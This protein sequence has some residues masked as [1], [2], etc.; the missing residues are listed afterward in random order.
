MQVGEPQGEPMR[1]G[2]I[3][4]SRQNESGSSELFR[5]GQTLADYNS[6]ASKKARTLPV[7]LLKSRRGIA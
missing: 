6:D 3:V 5:R 2:G 4:V 1:H 7:I